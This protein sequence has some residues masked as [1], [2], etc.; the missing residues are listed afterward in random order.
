ELFGKSADRLG[1]VE[2]QQ[3]VRRQV[4]DQR[5]RAEKAAIELQRREGL[6]AL[7]QQPEVTRIRLDEL[8]PHTVKRQ[9]YGQGARQHFVRRT[10]GSRLELLGRALGR[11]VEQADGVDLVAPQLDANWLAARREDVEDA[12]PPAE[13]A[14]RIDQRRRFVAEPEPLPGE[15]G[16]RQALS[17]FHGAVVVSKRLR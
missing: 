16:W 2:H 4:I 14:W 8:W 1:L 6:T 5:R 9:V 7:V 15:L 11:R 12:A 13:E 3:P 17:A 10:D